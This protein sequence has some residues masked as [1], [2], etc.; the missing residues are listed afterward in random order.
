MLL[1]VFEVASIG[2]TFLDQSLNSLSV[3]L[4]GQSLPLEFHLII[5]LADPVHLEPLF[6]L[7]KEVY[8][9]IEGSNL[10]FVLLI[11]Q[12]GLSFVDVGLLATSQS[13]DL[14]V[15]EGSVFVDETEELVPSFVFAF[16]LPDIYASAV[17]EGKDGFRLVMSR[18]CDIV[19]A[20]TEALLSHLIQLDLD[21]FEV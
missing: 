11:L 3:G 8:H 17:A 10:L 1:S 6:L 16:L 21:V 13:E 7:R 14:I 9:E 12:N 18:R 2:E 4:S 20:E 15:E 19:F 5:I